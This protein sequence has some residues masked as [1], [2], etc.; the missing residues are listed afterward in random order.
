MIGAHGETRVEHAIA[1]PNGKAALGAGGIGSA[2]EQGKSGGQLHT[3]L[4]TG[5]M[6][7]MRKT[8]QHRPVAHLTADDHVI[9]V[10]FQLATKAAAQAAHVLHDRFI[11]GERGE[12][13]ARGNQNARNRHYPGDHD[14]QRQGR[15]I[16]HVKSGG[17]RHRTSLMVGQTSRLTYGVTGAEE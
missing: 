9:A 6:F 4:Q 13:L 3:N 5:R 2:H 10:A 17:P 7:A 12:T 14:A 11:S 15:K 16:R 8:H 1:Q